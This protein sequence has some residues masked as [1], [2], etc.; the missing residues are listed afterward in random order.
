[1]LNR[2]KEVAM[3]VSEKMREYWRR[4]V[5]LTMVLLAI[6]FVVTYVVGFYARELAEVKFFG[7]PF[8][9]YMGAQ[10]AL[11]IYVIMIFYYAARMNRMDKEYNVAEEEE[12]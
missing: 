4:N 3:Q 12:E 5:S 1:V 7:F 11:V 8:S 6:W 10:G 2:K 9:F